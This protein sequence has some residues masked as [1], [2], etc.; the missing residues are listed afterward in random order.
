MDVL[1]GDCVVDPDIEVTVPLDIDV[2][3]GDGVG[4]GE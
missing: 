4:L 3:V 1:D 2:L